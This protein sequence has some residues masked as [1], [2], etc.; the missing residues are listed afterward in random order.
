MLM[1][2]RRIGERIVLDDDTEIVVAEIHRRTVRLGIKAGPGIQV[3]RGEVRDAV[4]QQNRRA[5]ESSWDEPPSDSE[6]KDEPPRV[7]SSS[8]HP[9]SLRALQPATEGLP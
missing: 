5:A 4:E 1:I 6:P 2:S 3:L 8:K 9:S 7:R